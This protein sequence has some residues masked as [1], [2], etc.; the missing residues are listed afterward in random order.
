MITKE[1]YVE[2]EVLTVFNTPYA[3]FLLFKRGSTLS[4]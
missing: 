2:I 3:Y 1:V 4:L